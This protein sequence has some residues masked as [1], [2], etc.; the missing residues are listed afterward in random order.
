MITLDELKKFQMFEG[1]E[2][3]VLQK[4]IDMATVKT[5]KAEELIYR[6]EAEADNFFIVYSGK[7]LLEGAVSDNITV[8]YSALK[9]GYVFGWYSLV[10]STHHFSSARATEESQIIEI[11]GDSLRMLM[12]ENQSFGYKFMNRM[13]MLLKMRL[14]RRSEQLVKILARHPDLQTGEEA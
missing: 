4:I 11:P 13:Y 3:D 10:P 2:N 6:S 1:L 12:D 7:A 8:S 14:D 5:Y 9:P